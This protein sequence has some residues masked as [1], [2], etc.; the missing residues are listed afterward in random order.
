MKTD[1]W[2]DDEYGGD[3]IKEFD[4]VHELYT[5]SKCIGLNHS[6]LLNLQLEKMDFDFGNCTTVF[7]RTT[8]PNDMCP[9]HKG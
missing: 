5:L 1:Y 7:G 3:P 4:H 2:C 9:M 8:S 6:D